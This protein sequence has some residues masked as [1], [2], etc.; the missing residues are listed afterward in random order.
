LA[1]VALTAS[2]PQ[3]S[4]RALVVAGF[5]AVAVPVTVMAPNPIAVGVVVTLATPI[6]PRTI[7]APRS[8]ETSAG[9]STS[10][11]VAAA[12]RLRREPLELSNSWLALR[13]RVVPFQ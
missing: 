12:V 6:H 4:V 7:P 9:S 11:A 10:A 5:H 1:V 8:G 2:L 3:S 13:L